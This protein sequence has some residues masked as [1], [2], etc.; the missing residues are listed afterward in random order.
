[1]RIAD[2][3]FAI[4]V[5][6]SMIVSV[7]PT[8]VVG[9][10][11][12]DA[13][14]VVSALLNPPAHALQLLRE[15]L[16]PPQQ[17]R[18]PDD[19]VMREL[20]R[21]RDTYRSQWHAARQEVA[22]L[23][24][25]L[26][27]FGAIRRADPS[28][29]WRLVDAAVGMAVPAAGQGVVRLLSGT[30]LGVAAGDVAIVRG[31]LL[32]GRVGPSPDRLSSTLIPI[33]HAGLGRIDASIVIDEAG[34]GRRLPVQ[35]EAIGE[36]RLGCDVALDGGVKPGMLVRLRDA[37]WPK[38]AQG[39]VLGTVVE[40]GRKDQQPLRGRAIILPAIDARNLAEVTIKATGQ[41]SQ[42]GSAP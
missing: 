17:V 37:S 23:E 12:V 8:R 25:K 3:P 27:Q 33:G 21:E 14:G 31:D 10:V 15:W 5:L 32:A 1:M 40:V 2:R 11:L 6:V 39:M 13:S 9:G 4:A 26:D 7:L 22:E 38:G 16:R 18:G 35:L 20:V 28:G 29:A 36:G 34:Q 41:S 42:S 30:A 24:R 19:P